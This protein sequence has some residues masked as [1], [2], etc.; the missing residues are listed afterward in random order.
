MRTLVPI[1]IGVVRGDKT[2]CRDCGV[3]IT[4]A[5]EFEHF[6]NRSSVARENGMKHPKAHEEFK[7]LIDSLGIGMRYARINRLDTGSGVQWAI[8]ALPEDIANE[9]VAKSLED[10]EADMVSII[11]NEEA[12]QFFIDE[13]PEDDHEVNAPVLEKIKLKK[14]LGVPLSQGD[15]DALDPTKEVD[16][17]KLN[18]TKGF[19]NKVLA[20]GGRLKK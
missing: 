4:S 17:V 6:H 15:L 1:K 16:G 18:K 19:K 20:V 12:E 14:D 7:D 3:K 9:Y 2:K 8:T 5:N 10:G 11:S 13:I